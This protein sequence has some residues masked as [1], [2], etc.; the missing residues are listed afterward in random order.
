MSAAELFFET[1]SPA[2]SRRHVTVAA[3][4]LGRSLT[5]LLALH[6]V[7]LNARCGQRGWCKGCLVELLEGELVDA[8]E[9]TRVT[10]GG[11]VRS[12]RM[13]LV[14]GS[15]V[16]LGI[17]EGAR[18][19]LAPQVGET[20]ELN[21]PYH[22]DPLFAATPERDLALAVDLGTTT[23]VV[24]LVDLTTGTVLSR[25]GGFNAQIRF[26]DNVLTRIGAASSATV[27]QAMR[28]AL[29]EETLAPLVAKACERAARPASRL[30]GVALAGNTTM[31]H[32]LA[33][34]D[35]TSLGIAPF[36][37]RFLA[38]RRLT[39]AEIGLAGGGVDPA[40]PWQLLPGLSAYVGAD[41]TAGVYATGMVYDD[42]PSLLVDM[43]TNGEVVLHAGGRLVGCATR[44][45]PAFE[46]AG[47]SSGT[48]AQAGA[49]ETIHLGMAPFA[50]G[51]E[52]IGGGP[53]TAEAG[54]CG[55]A[56][57]DFLAC[58]RTCGL[59]QENGRFDRQRWP[60][61]PAEY[62][63]ETEDGY[64]LRLKA[65]TGDDGPR[66]SEV[67]VAQLLQAKAAIGA[68]IDTLLE[69]TGISAAE[70]GRVYLAGGFGMHIDINHAITMGLLPGFTTEQVTVVGNTSLG[71][72]ILAVLDRAV[73]PGMEA[74]RARIEVVE[75]NLHDGFEDRY[76]DHLSL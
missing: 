21:V 64:A 52:V 72:A 32:I 14:P 49:V 22:L 34:E 9:G 18:I 50:L 42:L 57:V 27:R 26:G 46:G 30:A 1:G 48:R 20:F 76:I 33:D 5:D 63:I 51:V 16:V 35:P 36:T 41:L 59:L 40:L 2:G 56:Y 6:E 54:V 68:G 43:G 10:A 75:L 70:V 45:G 58:G 37:A 17:P 65:G 23:V 44:P 3:G 61:V 15:S 24:M 38:G 4:L 73:L 39:A 67:D 74:L 60:E 55:S 7:P 66:I 11:M 62:R 71:G 53:V 28:R 13:R 19:G 12:C 69:V 8:A 31:L 29:V 25:A 47:L